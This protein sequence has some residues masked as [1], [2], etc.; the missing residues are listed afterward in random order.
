MTR[1][2]IAFTIMVAVMAAGITW[3]YAQPRQAA[4][5]IA[6]EDYVE[7]MQLYNKY[8]YQTDMGGADDGT[9]YADLF[10]DDGQFRDY[11]GREGLKQNVKNYHRTLQE[12]GRISR[13][14]DANIILT[15]T[16]EGVNGTAYLIIFNASAQPPVI[17]TM[18]LY[19]D[20][21]VKTPQGWRF[22]KRLFKS[23]AETEPSMP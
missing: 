18:G 21:L 13:M 20:T 19:E 3:V 8:N 9:V 23:A 1:G 7:I 22:K 16:A 6:P 11:Q 4:G 10:T 5:T 2:R 17:T 12:S 15:P 14:I